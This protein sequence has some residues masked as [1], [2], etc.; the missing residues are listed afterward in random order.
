MDRFVSKTCEGEHCSICGEPAT[1]KVG[2]EIPYD[3]P[4]KERHNLTAYVCAKHFDLI[5]NRNGYKQREVTKVVF[6]AYNA[7]DPSVGIFPS[8][9]RVELECDHY[10][11]E[12]TYDEWIQFISEMHDV[13]KE[14][15][16]NEVQNLRSEIQM[17]QFERDMM[18]DEKIETDAILHLNRRIEYLIPIYKKNGIPEKYFQ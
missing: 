18:E 13:K 10:M 3:H 2:E 14:D 8:N 16:C 6:Y 9:M 12:D 11:D 15:V 7:G 1:N 17:L 5:M 4:H